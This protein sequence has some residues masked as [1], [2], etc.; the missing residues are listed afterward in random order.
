LDLNLKMNQINDEGLQN[1]AY[2][3]SFLD[4]LK[5]LKVDF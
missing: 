4:N 2:T 3:L 5:F 1:F